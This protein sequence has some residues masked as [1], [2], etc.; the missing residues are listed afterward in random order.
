[1]WSDFYCT[2]CIKAGGGREQEAYLEVA[3]SSDV[4]IMPTG[5]ITLVMVFLIAVNLSMCNDTLWY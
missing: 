3:D 1:L 4:D 5:H 2:V